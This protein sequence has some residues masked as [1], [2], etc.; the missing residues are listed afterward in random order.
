MV[1][2]NCETL[3]SLRVCYLISRQVDIKIKLYADGS[4]RLCAT[5]TVFRT[6]YNISEVDDETCLFSRIEDFLVPVIYALLPI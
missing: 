2:D 3:A 6:P 4:L 5:S 1:C